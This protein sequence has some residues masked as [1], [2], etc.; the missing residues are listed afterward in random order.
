MVHELSVSAQHP[1]G[2]IDRLGK[3]TARRVHALAQ[4]GDGHEALQGGAVAVDYQHAHRV[5]AAVDGGSDGHD[6]PCGSASR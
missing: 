6:A 2:P 5:G 1:D 3:Q 4:P